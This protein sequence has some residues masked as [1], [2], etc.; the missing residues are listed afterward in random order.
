MRGDREM[1][2]MI[3]CAAQGD[4]RVRAVSMEG[5][6]VN[7]AAPKDRYQDYDIT[8][9]VTDIG[10]FYNKPEWVLERFGEPL[11]MQMPEAMRYPD[12][13]G[14]FN[15]MMIYP[16]GNRIDLTFEPKKF[17]PAREPSVPLLD[18][19]GG[20]GFLPPDPAPPDCA[21]YNI[22][23][24]SPLYYYSCCNNFWWC[25][26]NVA[27]GIARDE[28]PYVMAMLNGVV[29]PELHD[30]ICWHIGA[31]RGFGVSAGKDCKYFKRLLPPY[32]YERYAATYSDGKYENIW[33]SVDAMC[34]L[35]HLLALEVAGH[36]GFVY[37]QN[38]EAGIREYM[39]IVKD[40]AGNGGGS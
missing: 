27:K 2:D 38:E 30:M 14:H 19:D 40:D 36:F 33:A 12:G 20:Q 25:L 4:E 16:D 22:E 7:P 1:L 32:L 37:R 26:N 10:P 39:R 9:Y 17:D 18:K 31:A 21:V 24:P 5:S 13:G 3:L 34:D 6:R 11:I 28:L 35:F 15:Y 29:R 8:F 23:P